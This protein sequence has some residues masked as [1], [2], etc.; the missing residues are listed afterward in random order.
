MVNLGKKL[1]DEQ[2]ITGYIINDA[3]CREE[4]TLNLCGS[5]LNPQR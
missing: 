2:R 4:M 3:D 1:E 5:S